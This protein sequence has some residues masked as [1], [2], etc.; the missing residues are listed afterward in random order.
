MQLAVAEHLD[1]LRRELQPRNYTE[2]LFVRE[3]ARHAACLDVSEAAELSTLRVGA[4][5][6][7]EF[8]GISDPGGLDD[9]DAAL[10][11][12]MTNPATEKMCKYRRSHERGFYAAWH[13]LQAAREAA[14][15][16]AAVP[17]PGRLWTDELA[18]EAYLWQQLAAEWSCPRCG[19]PVG[20]WLK[21]RARW[22]CGGCGR[23]SGLRQGTVMERS[24]LPL[25]KWFAAIEAV[26]V[27]MTLTAGQL[28]ELIDLPRLATAR[29][30]LQKILAALKSREADRRLAGLN[31]P[32][33]AL[34]WPAAGAPGC[35]VFRKR[36]DGIPDIDAAQLATATQ[37]CNSP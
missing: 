11:G 37:E 7:T 6:G 12:A 2:E 5:A 33:M 16:L 14:H 10:A 27:D 8:L 30:M 32:L 3:M 1:Q 22:E 21:T 31:R 23:Q 19:H 9:Q 26:T 28:A 34:H 29:G 36:P 18:C 4:Q 15:W 13:E 17:K 24:S 25:L 20:H 35:S